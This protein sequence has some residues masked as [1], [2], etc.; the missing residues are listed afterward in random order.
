[1]AV[2]IIIGVAFGQ[3]VSSFVVD[4]LMPPVGFLLG[5]IDFSTFSITL[6]EATDTAVA[7]TLNYGLFI[8]AIINFFIIAFAIFMV[9][10]QLNKLKKKEENKPAEPTEETLLLRE[11]SDRLKNK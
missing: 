10:K 1:M 5:G 8:N 6:K 7:V 3:I 4:I 11:I 2:G 9:I